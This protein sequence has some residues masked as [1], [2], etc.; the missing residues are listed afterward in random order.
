MVAVE[1]LRRQ[2]DELSLEKDDIMKE[3]Q[4]M[5]LDNDELEPAGATFGVLVK[6]LTGETIAL[7]GL[8]PSML[9]ADLKERIQK[10]LGTPVPQQRLLFA[11]GQMEDLSTLKTCNLKNDVT[12]HLVLR[13]RGGMYAPSSGRADLEK[14]TLKADINELQAGLRLLRTAVRDELARHERLVGGEKRGEK[15]GEELGEE[16]SGRPEK[17]SRTD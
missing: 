2:L 1:E 7:Q 4:R 12:L 9:V 10:Q 13:L 8:K 15:R 11:G 3:F 16:P 17:R 6:S 14:L 5:R